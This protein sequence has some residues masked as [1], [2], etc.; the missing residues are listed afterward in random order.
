MICAFLECLLHLSVHTFFFSFKWRKETSPRYSQKIDI[1]FRQNPLQ[2]NVGWSHQPTDYTG[3]QA[4]RNWVST[5]SPPWK[6]SRPSVF[7]AS[8]GSTGSWQSGADAGAGHS[9]GATTCT[10]A[11]EQHPAA[12]HSGWL[13]PIIRFSKTTLNPPS[14]GDW[15]F[16]ARLEVA[17]RSKHATHGAN[18]GLGSQRRILPSRHRLRAWKHRQSVWDN[19]KNKFKQ[20]DESYLFKQDSEFALWWGFQQTALRHGTLP[21]LLAGQTVPS[22]L[23]LTEQQNLHLH[24]RRCSG[25]SRAAGQLLLSD[26]E[27]AWARKTLT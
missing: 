17:C 23:S 27:R 21:F 14:D 18:Q 3:Q 7:L 9:A 15:R 25:E 10:A 26:M 2:V 8:P 1:N 4:G 12:W 6:C 16:Q 19:R 22:L 20:A 13:H 11:V 5:Q 24:P